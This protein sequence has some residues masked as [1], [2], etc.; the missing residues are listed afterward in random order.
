MCF[1]ITVQRY[2][3]RLI[4]KIECVKKYPII[5]NRQTKVKQTA[6]W[7]IVLEFLSHQNLFPGLPLTLFVNLYFHSNISVP[8]TQITPAME[9]FFLRF[10]L[11]VQTQTDLSL[12]IT[13]NF[14]STTHVNEQ[15]LTSDFLSQHELTRL[16]ILIYSILKDN[17]SDFN[18]FL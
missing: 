5:S 7:F 11:T 6:S 12:L 3:F 8:S 9:V 2:L 15:K 16:I 17:V 10:R 13:V 1:E 4:L 14:L 18:H